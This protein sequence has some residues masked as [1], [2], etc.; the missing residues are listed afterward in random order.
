MTPT[1]SLTWH[2]E[3]G[4]WLVRCVDCAWSTTTPDNDVARILAEQHA[5]LNPP[6]SRS[7]PMNPP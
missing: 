5:C 4:H 2:T 6:F 3:P 7:Y 1:V